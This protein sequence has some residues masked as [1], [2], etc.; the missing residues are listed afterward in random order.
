VRITWIGHST[1]VIEL[2]GLRVLTDP[3]LRARVAHLLR[4][5]P[6]AGDDAV[7]ELDAVLVSHMHHDHFDPPSLRKV[8]RSA[9]LIVPRGARKACAKIGFERVTELGVGDSVPVGPVTVTGTYA[10]HRGGR[11]LD[12]GPEAIGFIIGGSERAY[13]AGDTDIF[14]EMRELR[15]GLDVALLP[16]GGWGPKLG[17]G[18][19]DARRAAESLALLEPRV[20]VPIHWGTLYRM[21]MARSRRAL[22]ND[23]PQAFARQAAKVAPSV[24]VRILQPGETTTVERVDG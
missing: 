15:G 22:L 21:G 18:H 12:R 7:G 8:D 1:V 3:V 24:E 17:P 6:L 13:F 20:A 4:D 9:E 14:P 19:L 11:L 2:D 16:V 10:A 23:P 5:V